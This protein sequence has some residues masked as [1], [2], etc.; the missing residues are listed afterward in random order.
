MDE[1]RCTKPGENPRC[2]QTESRIH[3]P[4]AWYPA[5][6]DR[7]TGFTE[8]TDEASYHYTH[9]PGLQTESEEC[10]QL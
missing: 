7:F 4:Q 5:S 10:P 6:K 8:K 2:V 9:S 1:T 3:F